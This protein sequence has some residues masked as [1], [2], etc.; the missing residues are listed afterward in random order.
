M[1]KIRNLLV[2]KKTYIIAVVAVVLNFC[3]YMNWLTVDQITQINAVLAFLGLGTLRASVSR[4]Q[5]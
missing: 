5:E 3:V 2:G 4:S 1:N